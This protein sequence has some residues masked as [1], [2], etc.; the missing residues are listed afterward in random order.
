LFDSEKF[1]WLILGAETGNRKGKVVPEK[2]WIYD[3]YDYCQ[4]HKIPLFMKNSIQPYWQNEFN[5]DAL[6][7]IEFPVVGE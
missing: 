7:T 1:D 5:F 4:N 6:L 2:E 3:I